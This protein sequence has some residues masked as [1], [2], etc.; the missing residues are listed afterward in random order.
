MTYTAQGATIYA[1]GEAWADAATP[2]EAQLIAERLERL[3]AALREIRNNHGHVCP[4]FGT[5]AHVA[6]RDSHAAWQIADAAL[7]TEPIDRRDPLTAA[8]AWLAQRGA[9]LPRAWFLELKQ[10]L[11]VNDDN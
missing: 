1:G 7:G 2:M 4:D 11:G 8:R 3:D 5:C 10:A 6:C 9:G